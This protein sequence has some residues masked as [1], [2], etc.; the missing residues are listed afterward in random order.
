MNAK[1]RT[2]TESS[3]ELSR[4]RRE[5]ERMQRLTA[6]VIAETDTDATTNSGGGEK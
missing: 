5:V 1:C 3:A 4:E 2:T 6:P